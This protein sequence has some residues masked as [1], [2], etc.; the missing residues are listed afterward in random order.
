MKLTKPKRILLVGL[1]VAI[2]LSVAVY[3]YARIWKL[4]R[5]AR[6]SG[7]GSLGCG[8]GTVTLYTRA[9]PIKVQTVL[10]PIH[11]F[12]NE[13]HVK[14]LVS[15]VESR[16]R[17]NGRGISPTAGNLGSLYYVIL[18][19][20]SQSKDQTVIQ[21]ISELLD[22]PNEMI[23]AWAAIA[24]IRLGEQNE[25]LRDIIALVDFPEKALFGAR[26]RGVDRPL[27]LF[28]NKKNFRSTNKALQ[29]TPTSGVAEL[30]RYV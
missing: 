1:F 25:E 14:E 7:S 24:L 5:T 3:P 23:S 19:T 18:S 26:S 30:E 6:R 16:A 4:N 20:L 17:C 29:R 12:G 21:P 22:D 27:W 2:V 8:V 11:V 9:G 13:I 10:D 15:L 28:R